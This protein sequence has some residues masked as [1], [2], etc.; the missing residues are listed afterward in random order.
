MTALLLNEIAL[1]L[2][3]VAAVSSQSLL[4]LTTVVMFFSLIWMLRK[5]KS[6]FVFQKIGI[7]WAFL[8]Y[9][10][11]VILGFAINASKEAEWLRS[12]LKFSWLINIYILILVLQTVEIETTRIV[13]VLSAL[14]LGP[15]LY[16]LISYLQGFDLITG[17]DNV[18]ITGL[19][20]SS[21]YHAHGNAFLF[22]FL[23]GGIFF[24]FKK[25][26]K[27]W[28]VFSLI[29]TFLLGVSILLTFTRGVWLS[30]FLST[31]MILF[32]IDWKKVLKFTGGT[33]TLFLLLFFLWPKFHDRIVTTSN[34]DY[35]EMR[36][37]LFKVNVQI[38]KE[39]PLLGIGFGEN[40]RR[41]REYWDRP[42]WN[43][44]ADYLTSH[45]HNQFLN[46]LA[47][48]GIFGFVFF[49][50]FF[51]FFILKNVKMIQKTNR[52]QTP[53]RFAILL[54]C[55]WAQLQFLLAC[56]SDVGFEYAKIR[57]L[58]LLV[59]A[60]VIAIEQKPSIVKEL[61]HV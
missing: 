43:K 19:V 41:N 61:K 35:N 49:C 39:Y 14:S 53:E 16:S 51:F 48:T 42:E 4:D 58:I 25:L 52:L 56:W 38:W 8:A 13:K 24:S 22:V 11:V 47:T 40:I 31:I 33:I 2:Y 20:N 10:V 1:A 26:P 18:R 50:W 34:S 9:V 55:L 32:F 21:T 60:L 59:W 27:F 44:P 6:Q 45:A 17:R 37:S 28:K 23:V 54:I 12:F 7:E 30:I 29:S 15:T 5:N 46:V 36:V 57:A 3:P